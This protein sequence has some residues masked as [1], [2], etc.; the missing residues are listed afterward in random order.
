MLKNILTKIRRVL[1]DML[2]THK[3]T[4]VFLC[5]YIIVVLVN[6][7]IF[8]TLDRQMKDVDLIY[9]SNHTSNELKELT[10]RVQKSMT[11]YMESKSTDGMEEYYK[12]V[13]N[14]QQSVK[15]LD[16][17]IEGTSFPAMKD[18]LKHLSDEYIRYTDLTIQ[19]KRGRNIEAYRVNFDKATK[20]YS[21]I[22]DSLRAFNED[23][24]KLNTANYDRFRKVMKSIET[25]GLLILGMIILGGCVLVYIITSRITAPLGK[26]ADTAKEV[27]SGNLDVE[28]PVYRRSDE[29]GTLSYAIRHMLIDI[30]DYIKRQQYIMEK[31]RKLKENELKMEANI[32]EARLKYFQAQIDPHFL[33]NT[34]NAGVSLA[35]L[36]N[37]PR[38]GTYIEDVAEFFRYNIKGV[39]GDATLEDE[40]RLADYY[41]AIL[42]VRFK[43]EFE[44]IKDIDS[45]QGKVRMP[46][47]VLQPILEN[48]VNHGIRNSDK[49]GRIYL[50]VY[51]QDDSVI[52]S[53]ADNGVGMSK[54][55]IDRI[56][57]GNYSGDSKVK[58]T[59]GVGL[60]NVISRLKLYYGK[61][62][63]A[64]IIS[65][66]EDKGTEV[67][68]R[69]PK[70]E[71]V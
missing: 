46:K 2:I 18:D 57:K 30:K 1:N 25:I 60:S 45:Q 16:T 21:F 22:Q 20:I 29:I 23:Q 64:D 36:E 54:D 49:K 7:C 27:S 67:V 69:I 17:T 47:M 70:G 5:F 8:I 50:T 53:I 11:S 56:L 32:K 39:E 52:V 42:K 68:L 61:D 24:F 3:L 63:V 4:G 37:A 38:T 58:D 59:N 26:L 33:F 13:Y 65:E 62:D 40:L 44:L 48:C 28:F 19:Q 71:N 9:K 41:I 34:L 10:T 43:D 31:E 6:L 14:L 55:K 15:E 66:G 12:A 51:S 35:M